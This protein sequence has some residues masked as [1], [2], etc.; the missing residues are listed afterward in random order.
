MSDI[1]K[2][3]KVVILGL[4]GAGGRI[5]QQLS[6]LP[7]SKDLTLCV[8]DTD[9][10]ALAK[11]DGI[12]EDARILC[13]EQWL[14]G[15]GTGGDV[16][17]GQR[18][19]S[20]ESSKLQEIMRDTSLLVLTGGLGG[21]TATGGAGVICNRARSHNLTMVSLFE[22]PFSFEGHGRSKT[23]EDG[24]RE[25]LSLS[26]TVLS[27]PNDLLF[28]VLP[29]ETAFADAFRMADEEIARTIL[30]V[31][32][33]L[34]PGNLLSADIGDLSAILRGRKSYAA[35]GVGVANGKTS[36]ESCTGALAKLMDSP[37]LGGAAK[38]QEADA[39][40]LNLTGGTA[41]TVSDVQRTLEHA[42][43]L[44]GAGAKVLAGANVDDKMLNEVHITAI[45]VKYDEREAAAPAAAVEKA[46]RRRTRSPRQPKELPV[47]QMLPLTIA[48]S[49]IFEGKTPTIIDG[50]NFDIPAFVRRQIN[51][52]TGE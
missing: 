29:A 36:A 40:I 19:L 4:G 24:L 46:P 37:F 35:V 7:V 26:D 51:I 43:S 3:D 33:V 2:K 45:A 47:Q 49:G 12:A 52:D 39:V 1:S 30:G 14:R 38:L 21:G 10:R 5:V 25:L 42:G 31:V 18:A 13:D 44:P 22:L 20:R 15:Q 17:K 9:S 27:I 32:D 48:S 23:A 6:K 41:L 28:S 50:V 11:L 34:S 16:M 8:F